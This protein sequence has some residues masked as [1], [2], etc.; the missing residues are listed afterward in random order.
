[1]SCSQ[2]ELEDIAYWFSH[3]EEE[4]IPLF[5]MVQLLES[6]LFYHVCGLNYWNALVAQQW[7]IITG[8]N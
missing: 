8:W 5:E 6:D 7:N 2:Q 4:I 3:I 1:M